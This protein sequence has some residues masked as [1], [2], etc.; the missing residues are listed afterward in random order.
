MPTHVPVHNAQ[1]NSS[2][3]KLL[4]LIKFRGLLR[5]VPN[6]KIRVNPKQA[7]KRNRRFIGERLLQNSK[8]FD[9][10]V[11]IYSFRKRFGRDIE[12]RPIPSH[13]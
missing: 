8:I 7:I 13:T 1:F 11:E 6:I 9:T 2:L 3:K 10:K 4:F 12:D 5:I